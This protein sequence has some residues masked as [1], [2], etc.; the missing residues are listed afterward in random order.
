[1]SNIY[2]IYAYIRSSNETPYYI[3]KGKGNRAWKYHGKIGVPKDK[4]RI[5]IME[6]GLTEIGALALERRY[7]R[8]YG[9]EDSSNGILL[10]STDGGD[11]A[12]GYKHSESFKEKMRNLPGYWKSKSIPK[13]AKQKMSESKLGKKR[14]TFTEEHRKKLS[15]A[16]K[17]QI[18]W[19]LGKSLSI[20][21]RKKMS[22]SKKGKSK[23]PL[24]Q[25]HRKK[26]SE[27]MQR[28]RANKSTSN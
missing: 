12:S 15:E 6:S 23:A 11:G 27:S 17:N 24:S 7:I 16:N 1:M 2:Y 14:P 4:S 25:D 5:V 26:I 19:N 21:T 18:P 22:G 9:R 28:Y 20:E 10:N 8:W 3:G 13:E